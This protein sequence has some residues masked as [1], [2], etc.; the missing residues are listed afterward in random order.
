MKAIISD[1][2]VFDCGQ[3][4][5]GFMCSG[6]GR[7]KA[8]EGQCLVNGITE[9]KR[10]KTWIYYGGGSLSIYIYIYRL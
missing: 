1:S 9:L 10:A 5:L 4:L 7:Y 2:I 8:Y 6:S 3:N